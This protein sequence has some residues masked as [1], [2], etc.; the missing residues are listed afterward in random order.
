MRIFSYL[1]GWFATPADLRAVK[2]GRTPSE[3]FLYALAY[4]DAKRRLFKIGKTKDLAQRLRSYRTVMPCSQGWFHTVRVENMHLSEKILHAM[5]KLKGYHVER[6]IFS[7]DGKAIRGLMDLTQ[8][9][10]RLLSDRSTNA[11]VLHRATD[12]LKRL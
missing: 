4:S 11:R 3:Q 9:L 1:F 10:D 6:E 12:A 2:A 5:L 8:Q 7:G